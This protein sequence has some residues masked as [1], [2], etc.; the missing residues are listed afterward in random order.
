M[1]RER[2]TGENTSK[3]INCRFF[4]FFGLGN[5]RAGDD[6]SDDFGRFRSQSNKS[7]ARSEREIAS[8]RL[9]ENRSNCSAPVMFAIVRVAGHV[10][11]V[12]EEQ[13]GDDA[14]KLEEPNEKKCPYCRS[15]IHF[16]ATRCPL[17][18]SHLEEAQV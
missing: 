11:D 8:S 9:V 2:G 12:L 4:W 17:C 1:C 5:H 18:T 6:I 7:S 10:D 15:V 14:H 3:S 16:K 13:F